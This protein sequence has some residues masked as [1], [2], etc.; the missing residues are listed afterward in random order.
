MMAC[1]IAES[2][3]G[4]REGRSAGEQGEHSS[5]HEPSM[6]LANH[7]V[8]NKAIELVESGKSGVE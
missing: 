3:C 4:V 2:L 7:A 6:N 5:W 1:L 8:E